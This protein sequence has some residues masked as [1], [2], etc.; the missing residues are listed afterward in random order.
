MTPLLSRRIA[1]FSLN[2]WFDQAR[3]VVLLLPMTAVET[4]NWIDLACQ[5]NLLCNIRAHWLWPV[6]A[7]ARKHHEYLESVSDL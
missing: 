4:I 5:S 2:L 1:P 3:G 7:I 6:L